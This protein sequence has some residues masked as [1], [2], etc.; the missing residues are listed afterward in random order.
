MI[1]DTDVYKIGRVGK[2][3]GVKG[4]V[5]VQIDDDVFDRVGA[6]YLVLRIDGILV[7]FFMEEYRFKSDEIALV[8]FCD[9]DSAEKVRE[10]TGCE[11]FFPRSLADEV[12]HDLTYAE[13]VGYELTDSNTGK[14]VGT[15]EAVD[16]ATENILFEL[17]NGLLIPAP[18]ELIEEVDTECRKVT[19]AVPEGLLDGSFC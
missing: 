6:D 4:E 5:Q 1:K 2:P 19:V 10:L 16:D 8:T 12:E 15:I 11:V 13:L 18:E 3:H 14:T 9:M 7:P 17:D